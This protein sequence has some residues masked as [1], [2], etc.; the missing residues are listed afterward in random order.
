MFDNHTPSFNAFGPSV[1]EIKRNPSSRSRDVKSWCTC[2]T[3]MC[4]HVQMHPTHDLCDVHR[5]F[6]SKHT[7]SW[8]KIGRV[9]LSYSSTANFYTPQ[10]HAL[11]VTLVELHGKR[12]HVQGVQCPCFL[13]DPTLQTCLRNSPWDFINRYLS[14]TFHGELR[15][16]VMHATYHQQ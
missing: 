8:A 15:K 4:A 7:Q 12:V 11:T 13:T 10:R 5:Y 6:V 2:C 9:F 16:Y 14:V 3:C 1:P